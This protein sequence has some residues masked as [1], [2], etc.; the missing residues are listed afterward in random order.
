MKNVKLIQ[1]RCAICR[2]PIDK[3]WA[4]ENPSL[5]T[6]CRTCTFKT[7]EPEVFGPKNVKIKAKKEIRFDPV[8][9]VY[10]YHFDWGGTKIKVNGKV[11][12]ITKPQADGDVVRFRGDTRGLGTFIKGVGY[13]DLLRIY[14]ETGGEATPPPLDLPPYTPEPIELL[15]DPI[16]PVKVNM[17]DEVGRI[18]SVE[19]GDYGSEGIPFIRS[20]HAF[21]NLYVRYHFGLEP[22][23]V[24]E[25]GFTGKGFE[26]RNFLW[27][28]IGISVRGTAKDADTSTV[29]S[30]WIQVMTTLL[31][32]DWRKE[33]TD[34]IG[35]IYQCY[36]RLQDVLL[37]IMPLPELQRALD[38]ARKNRLVHYG[39]PY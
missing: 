39:M 8:L 9:G 30:V 7:P 23:Y 29:L 28:G 2:G 20:L 32:Y 1:G 35:G 37:N 6:R 27:H 5:G 10:D 36:C 17:D 26:V 24:C 13:W 21:T 12:V 18:R 22:N 19:V 38:Y 31:R 3:E 16:V 33:K 14:K 4:G 34:T 15:E 25:G 11:G